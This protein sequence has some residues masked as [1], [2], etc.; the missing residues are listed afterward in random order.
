MTIRTASAKKKKKTIVQLLHAVANSTDERFQAQRCVP[1]VSD[2]VLCV[3]GTEFLNTMYTNFNT[4][5]VKLRNSPRQE[6]NINRHK[7][8]ILDMKTL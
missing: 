5:R 1:T 8:A 2:F 3:A 6:T 4:Q 7:L